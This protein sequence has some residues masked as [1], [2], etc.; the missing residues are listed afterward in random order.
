MHLEELKVN[1]ENNIQNELTLYRNSVIEEISPLFD[2]LKI[3][4]SLKSFKLFFDISDKDLVQLCTIFANHPNLEHFELHNHPLSINSTQAISAMLEVSPM[5]NSLTISNCL[6]NDLTVLALSEAIE[7]KKSLLKLDIHF[8]NLLSEGTVKRL[9][10]AVSKPSL[11]EL[12]I[13]QDGDIIALELAKILGQNSS[14]KLL[15][16]H[17][18]R[19]GITD[20]G[21]KALADVLRT[22]YCLTEL[23]L[24]HNTITKGGMVALGQLLKI[25]KT[26]KLLDIMCNEGEDYAGEIFTPILEENFSVTNIEYIGGGNT[27]RLRELLKR[28][29]ECEPFIQP[30]L[31]AKEILQGKPSLN[32][33]DLVVLKEHKAEI[34][35]FAQEYPKILECYKEGIAHQIDLNNFYHM[36]EEYKNS[37]FLE[38]HRVCKD[39]Y[40]IKAADTNAA[41]P[42][43][44][45]PEEILHKIFAY[46]LPMEEEVVLTAV[47]QEVLQPLLGR[48]NHVMDIAIDPPSAYF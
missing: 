17:H 35:K 41:A 25:N 43:T 32:L 1:L 44:S 2:S 12:I 18:A 39:H 38:L 11:K 40:N 30:L 33:K 42:I 29:K 36:L 37:N 5:L 46:I 14:L 47:S 20:I 24:A 23:N 4:I 21:A 8:Y 45:V 3:N 34:Y 48:V 9:V 7:S 15:T 6:L 16:I 31:K 22:N 13:W 10:E 27:K 26:L 19:K 28:N